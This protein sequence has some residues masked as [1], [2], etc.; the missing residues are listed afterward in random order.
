MNEAEFKRRTKQLALDIIR[1][2]SALPCDSASSVIARQLLRRGTSVSANYRSACRG[3][4]VPDVLSRLAIVE[5]EA[6]E[7]AYWL[8]LLVEAGIANRGNVEPILDET[9]QIVAMTVASIR[10]LRAR[11]GA[12]PKSKISN[13][14]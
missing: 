4:S 6:D 2:T 8:E 5:E 1:P 7:T 13:L 3:R 9:N 12:A 11:Q 10:T 14:K